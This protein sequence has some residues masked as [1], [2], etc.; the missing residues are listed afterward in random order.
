M[1]LQR[2]NNCGY[3]HKVEVKVLNAPCPKC[4]YP[5]ITWKPLDI[6]QYYADTRDWWDIVTGTWK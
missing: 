2:C 4:K 5:L 1:Y 6:P 3:M